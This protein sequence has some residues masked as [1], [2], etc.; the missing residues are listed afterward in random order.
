MRLLAC[1]SM[2]VAVALFTRDLRVRDN[3]VLAAAVRDA[4]HVDPAV[5]PRRRHAR[6]VRTARPI[7]SASCSSRSRISTS[8][9]DARGGRLVVRRGDWVHEVLAVAEAAGAETVHVAR[10]VSGFAQRRVAR[11]QDAARA[12]DVTVA[13]HESVTVVPPD[14]LR[15]SSGGPFLVFTPYYKR[16]LAQPWRAMVAMPRHVIGAAHGRARR[17]PRSLEAHEGSARRGRR[18]GGETEGIARLRGWTRPDSRPMRSDHDDLAGRPDV[19]HLAVPALR[20][21]LGA[22][23]RDAACAVDRRRGVRPRS[24]AGATSSRNCSPPVPRP[25]TTTCAPP[26]ARGRRTTTALEAW[27]TGRTGY[28]VVDAGMRQLVREGWMHNRARMVVA[29]FLTKDLMIDWRTG[30]EYFMRHLVDGD[31]AQNQLNWQWVA[32]P[33]TDTN[34]HRVYNPT[35]Q[36]R[37]FDP[38]GVYIRR[39]VASSPT[40]RGRHDPS[41]RPRPR[42]IPSRSSTTPR[43]SRS[44]ARADGAAPRSRRVAPMRRSV[45]ARTGLRTVGSR[46]CAP[47]RRARPMP[48]RERYTIAEDRGPLRQVTSVGRGRRSSA[49]MCFRAR[50]R[51]RTRG[52]SAMMFSETGTAACTC[53]V[54]QTAVHRRELVTAEEQPRRWR[55]SRGRTRPGRSRHHG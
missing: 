30:A 53:A 35:V 44:R 21:P 17:D 37:K 23:G 12:R 51:S 24:S 6:R 36:G 52:G 11:L 14:A 16:W 27:H 43:P 54:R 22:R 26:R 5:R 19:A 47:R 39:Y 13:V 25:R 9:L 42:G 55:R 10:D 29:S 8:A 46:R 50:S 4:D 49:A 48:R 1:H 28:P 31:V 7:A 15:S 34:P 40:A 32:G 33:G 38:D 3:P 41:L 18:P 20:L 2:A 45:A